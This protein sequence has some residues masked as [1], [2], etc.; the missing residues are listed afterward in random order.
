MFAHEP[1]SQNY[2]LKYTSYHGILKSIGIH[3]LK[4]L[5]LWQ[6]IP[7]KKKWCL[8]TNCKNLRVDIASQHHIWEGNYYAEV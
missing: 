1:M 6:I 3:L 5:V 2:S 4:H 8:I 7:K